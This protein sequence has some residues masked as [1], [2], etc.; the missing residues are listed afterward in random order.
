MAE[1]IFPI[2]NSAGS[3]CQTVDVARMS[4]AG[5]IAQLFEDG[6]VQ[7]PMSACAG[8][9]MCPGRY[10]AIAEIKMVMAMLLASFEVESVTTPD[11]GE[12]RAGKPDPQPVRL[13][14]MDASSA[15][16]SFTKSRNALILAGG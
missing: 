5:E 13:T 10:L 7:S 3:E 2:S 12:P 9:R 6:E 8:P 16:I 1:A 14:G 11:G 4:V 15:A